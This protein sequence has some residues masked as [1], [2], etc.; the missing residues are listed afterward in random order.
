MAQQETECR[1]PARE[2]PVC[3]PSPLPHLSVAFSHPKDLKAEALRHTSTLPSP[4]AHASKSKC[5]REMCRLQSVRQQHPLSWMQCVSFPGSLPTR[6]LQSPSS[7]R[8]SPRLN[9]FFFPPA[10]HCSS[11]HTAALPWV[12][13]RCQ[14][15]SSPQPL[16]RPKPGACCNQDPTRQSN[17]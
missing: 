4:V 17:T 9:P 7:P 16:H 13:H 2:L 3:S 14:R 5:P 15:S 8:K 11:S 10:T 6:P 1:A 12:P